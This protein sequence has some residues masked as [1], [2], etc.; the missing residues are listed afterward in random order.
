MLRA[1]AARF[2]VV[3]LVS[4]VDEMLSLGG[5]PPADAAEHA[6]KVRT[7]VPTIWASFSSAVRTLLQ[8]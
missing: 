6:E 5:P 8:V 4:R 2:S 7:H 1:I 3:P